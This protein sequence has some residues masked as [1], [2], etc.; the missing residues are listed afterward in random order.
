[1]SK[2]SNAKAGATTGA[3]KGKGSKPA[4][5]RATPKSPSQSTPC[6]S[7]SLMRRW[8]NDDVASAA[9]GTHGGSLVRSE[10]EAAPVEKG[11]QQVQLKRRR[12]LELADSRSV[13]VWGV[14]DLSLPAA[15]KLLCTPV[16]PVPRERV[17]G[18]EVNKTERGPLLSIT[19]TSSLTRSVSW[20][21]VEQACK[22][23]GWKA[24]FSRTYLRRAMHRAA[25]HPAPLEPLPCSNRFAPLVN[26][27][28]ELGSA[29]VSE[30]I[31]HRTR[32]H[33]KT[34]SQ[35]APGV[36]DLSS[37]LLGSLNV[38]GGL[39]TKGGELEEYILSKGVDVLAL[40]ETRLKLGGSEP[41]FAAY[42]L[43]HRA[44]ESGCGGVGF[45]VSKHLAPLI[46]ILP[47]TTPEQL[48]ISFRGT[49]GQQNLCMCSAYMPQ[50]SACAEARQSAWEALLDRTISLQNTNAVVIAGDLNARMGKS[51]IRENGVLLNRFDQGKLSENGKLLVKLLRE[52]SMVSLG[53]LTQPHGNQK[54]WYTRHDP[55]TGTKSQIDHILT[56]LKQ[57]KQFEA[58]FK[59]DYTSLDSDHHLCLA[60]VLAPKKP[61]PARDR[62]VKR[63]LVEKLGKLQNGKGLGPDVSASHPVEPEV[64]YDAK[65]ADALKQAFGADYSPDQAVEGA[66]VQGLDAEAVASDF[67]KRLERALETS[68]GS[69][70]IS[71]KF[72]RPWFCS[73]VKEAVLARRKAY[74]V[75]RKSELKSDWDAYCVLRKAARVLVRAKQKENWSKLSVQLEDS[76]KT[77][78]KLHWALINRIVSKRRSE[79]SLAI[80]RADGSLAFSESERREAWGDYLGELG[81]PPTSTFFDATFAQE[82]SEKIRAC[83]V[84][85]SHEGPH[86]L[87]A[88]FS[89]KEWDEAVS[90]LKCGKAAGLDGVRNEALKYAGEALRTPGLRLFNW[91]QKSE[92]IPQSWGKSLTVF[93]YKDGETSDPSNYRGISLISCLAKLYLNMWTRRLSKH[94]EPQLSEE[95]FGFRG[96]RTTVDAVFA[97]HEALLRRKRN[98]QPTYC[99]FI[100]FRKAF[101]YVWR[102]GLWSVLW[103]MGVRGKAWRILRK[104]Y[105]ATESAAL[106]EGSPSA[107]HP[108]SA[109]VRQ[110]DPLS[111]LLFIIFIDGLAAALRETGVGLNL[112]DSTLVDLLFA[113]DVALLSDTVEGL[114]TLI[115]VVDNY[116][117]KW[118]LIL[119]TGK[120]K[121]VVFNPSREGV[122]YEWDYR[123]ESLEQ[124]PS[125]KYLGVWF[126]ESLS[127]K[128]H[129][130]KLVAKGSKEC[131][132]FTRVFAMRNLPL[133]I[134]VRVW[135]TMIRTMLEYGAAVW[136]TDANSE[137]RLE[138]LQHRV[139]TRILRVN[140]HSNRVAPR[141]ILG[142]P[143]L[144]TRRESARLR[145][146]AEVVTKPDT[147]WVKRIFS[148]PV[149]PNRVKGPT[150]SHW[151]VAVE[152][153]I[154][155][156]EILREGYEKFT[157]AL[158]SLRA[159]QDVNGEEG[160]RVVKPPTSEWRISVKKWQALKEAELTRVSSNT[161]LK[162]LGRVFRDDQPEGMC[163]LLVA[164]RPPSTANWVR[165]RLL[166]GTHGLNSMMHRITRAGVNERNSLCPLCNSAEET[167]EHFLLECSHPPCV[168]LRE[169]CFAVLSEE[170]VGTGFGVLDPLGRC[171]LILGGLL[172]SHGP[173]SLVNDKECE[174]FVG[175]L[176]SIRCAALTASGVYSPMTSSFTSA[177]FKFAPVERG[178]GAH[179]TR[180]TPD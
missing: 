178:V 179:G 136:E 27:P 159:S 91:I 168:A 31:S 52:A 133:G 30:V 108:V 29:A 15:W 89:I 10:F 34:T 62:K 12:S 180:A 148:L 177:L 69:K 68:V 86:V 17:A 58:D 147:A 125:Y 81:K 121:V 169:K 109:G 141:L 119:N 175:G 48:W 139:L 24:L 156:H 2:V 104:V 43:F 161:T 120:T 18:L 116:C 150:R 92:S 112:G 132:K 26:P 65:F 88:D 114:Q 1:M 8:L 87:D 166:N 45:L 84:S 152:K 71:K 167:V 95:Q 46:T 129:I 158:Q 146:I 122:H 162:M 41:R 20:R 160:E 66:Q 176:W 113:D 23:R 49:G 101:D 124:V 174:L 111:P 143:S 170:G 37:I 165:I 149:V 21:L 72:S 11:W 63:F 32:R 173:L 64:S 55:K 102:D 56:G 53:P 73:E 40:Q 107:F 28:N 151:R 135:T 19:F 154:N 144:L 140:S 138:S 157:A 155:Q 22:A 117:R 6:A 51:Y 35:R 137:K 94:I 127:W 90:S 50:E 103:D 60:K 171:C 110:G 134:K 78:A 85:S 59:V 13:V 9:E 82:I 96:K 118:R 83:T 163:P 57:S 99:C 70:I 79:Q 142:L 16:G 172:S 54:F 76:Q 98:R 5:S 131:T 128:L 61:Q 126:H 115:N 93:L 106:V 7:A 74:A 14:R 4:H 39:F 44:N 33:T 130:E 97:L 36:R 47:S 100:D 25:K 67:V 42:E 164:T 80:R 75:F 105:S 3:R 145:Y 123:G 77:N 38:Q 153:L